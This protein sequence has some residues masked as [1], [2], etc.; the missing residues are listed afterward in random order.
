[1][2]ISTQ[3]YYKKPEEDINAYNARIAGLRA[4]ETSGQ[5]QVGQPIPG[6]NLNYE[7]A[8]ITNL[9]SGGN[10]P[11]TS[12]ALKGEA[13]QNFQTPT[14]TPA[15][16]VTPPEKPADLTG[17]Q[18]EESDLTKEL[19]TLNESMVGRSAFEA[20]QKKEQGYGE[21]VKTQ[22]SLYNQILN[23]QAFTENIPSVIQKESEGRGRT[24]AG[25]APLQSAQLRDAGIQANILK[26]QY[27]AATEDL[28]TAKSLVDE[29]VANKFNPLEE[30]Q[31]ALLANLK[32]IQESP[33][34]TNEEKARAEAKTKEIKAEEAKTAA[35]K[36]AV[37][38]ILN[39][40][41]NAS[42][43][44]I[45]AVA[46]KQITDL[47]SGEKGLKATPAEV[48][49][50]LELARPFLEKKKEVKV[51]S[52]FTQTQENQGAATARLPISGFQS[53]DVD[54]QNTFINN[55]PQID[56]MFEAIDEDLGKD[57]SEGKIT[58]LKEEIES[59][60]LPKGVKDILKK[61]VDDNATVKPP[62][63]DRIKN[64]FSGIF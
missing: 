63:V 56:K 33:E 44:G 25:V 36:E 34:A 54:T 5:P 10:S 12:D 58:S 37:D 55:A 18:K 15:L 51:E 62:L 17:V 49:K 4:S 1:M 38:D 30:K 32:L 45:D 14:P 21:K 23:L 41:N 53:L 31:K 46:L 16:P 40:A 61:Y 7:Q 13:T 20:E 60:N 48:A 42:A 11:I 22:K 24:A 9:A 59:A 64:F 28:A 19:R 43:Q 35:A 57:I 8:D 2:A 50:A 52:R 3:Q 39:I 27:L 29:A 26:A 6:T 47:V